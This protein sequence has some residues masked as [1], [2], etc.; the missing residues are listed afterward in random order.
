MLAIG[1]TPLLF[2]RAG[3]KLFK[4]FLHALIQILDVLAGVVGKRVACAGSPNQILPVRVE[5]LDDQRACLIRV[6]SAAGRTCWQIESNEAK[7][8]WDWCNRLKVQER[9]VPR[10][11]VRWAAAGCISV[12]HLPASGVRARFW[13]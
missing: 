2:R 10:N 11:E 4:H 6:E 5:P 1:N 9:I 8:A 12:N 3:R 7:S 13:I